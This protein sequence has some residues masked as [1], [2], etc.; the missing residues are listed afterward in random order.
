MRTG[1]HDYIMKG[2]LK[3]LV[4][5]VERELR[6]AESRF[7]ATAEARLVHLA[8]HDT[9]TDL[10]NRVLLHDRLGCALLAAERASEPLGLLIL[11][12]DGFKAINDSLGHQAGDR[13]LQ[14]LAARPG[15]SLRDG[16]TVA[17][18]G[19]EFAFVLPRTD[20]DGA[21][22]AGREVLRAVDRSLVLDGRP[23]ELRGSIGIACSR[24][25]VRRRRM[26]LQKA[27]IAMYVAKSGGLGYACYAPDR[28]RTRHRRLTLMTELRK[29]SR[30]ASSR[31]TTSRSS[32]SS[33]ARSGRS[34]RWH[35]G[36]IRARGACRRRS[37]SAS[38]S[39]P[40]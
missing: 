21:A 39:R 33:P 1:A 26:L 17:L 32:A 8:Y 27:D 10:P 14:E 12:L 3:R 38:P 13:V 28:D 31:S 6:E 11:D 24:N 9:L 40:A 30:T 36:T 15:P 5:A 18:G 20:G 4:P 7:S 35:D 34:R 29:G 37:S 23:L 19:D 16:D 2:S 22:R 25:T